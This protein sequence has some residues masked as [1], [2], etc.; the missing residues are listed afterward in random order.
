LQFPKVQKDNDDLTLFLRF[1]I[2][3]FKCCSQNVDEID[4]RG[5]DLLPLACRVNYGHA[6]A[7]ALV[8]EKDQK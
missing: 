8:N 5:C 7:I 3:A 1:G 2:F 6:Q 4:P